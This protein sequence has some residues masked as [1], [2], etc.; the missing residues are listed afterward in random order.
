MGEYKK[1][2]SESINLY[3][4]LEIF[5]DLASLQTIDTKYETDLISQLSEHFNVNFNFRLFYDSDIST[6][7]QIRQFF[8]LGINYE[9]F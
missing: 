8:S 4:K 3:S 9:F 1:I 7:R 5:S 6:R 2:F